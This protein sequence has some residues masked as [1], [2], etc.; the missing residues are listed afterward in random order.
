MDKPKIR[1]LLYFDFEKASSIWSQ[2]QWGQLE[3]ISVTAEESSETQIG[4]GLGIPKVAEANLH[5]GEGEKRTIIETRILHHDLLNRIENYLS[6]SGLIINLNDSFIDEEIAS[7]EI[8]RS[9]IGNKPFIIA[10]GWSVIEDYQRI[11]SISDR[12]NDLAEF[13]GRSA[14]ENIKDSPEYLELSNNLENL[15]NQINTIKDRNKKAFEKNKIKNLE[16]ELE[17]MLESQVNKVDE[18]VLEGI[19][20]W[21]TTFL[22]SRINFRVYPFENFPSFQILCNLKRD[23]FVDQDLE[24]LLYGYGNHPN[25]QLS[26]FG[27]ITSIPPKGH[28]IFDPLSEFNNLEELTKEMSFEKAFRTM[29]DAMEGLEEFSKYSRY[30]NITVHPIAVFRELYKSNNDGNIDASIS[31]GKLQEESTPIKRFLSSFF[32]QKPKFSR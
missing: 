27:L 11:L 18:W 12:F 10:Q 16:E 3:R 32:K 15:N 30:P 20:N 28:E 7:P 24:H 4:G 14:I 21:I 31:N 8:I 1:D 17:K 2:L 13:I 19:K 23:S 29:F 5:I 6:S 25:I 9:A 22:P 26:I